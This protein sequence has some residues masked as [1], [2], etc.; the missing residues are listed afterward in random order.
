MIGFLPGFPYMG[1][2]DD[3]IAMPR[4]PSPRVRVP[5]GSVGIAGRQT[6]IYPTISPG[7]WQLIGRTTC[8]LFDVARNPPAL[9]VPGQR[10]RFVSVGPAAGA[11]TRPRE[12]GVRAAGRWPGDGAGSGPLGVPGARCARLR[13]HGHLVPS[14]CQPPRGQSGRGRHHRS[15]GRRARAGLLRRAHR[16]SG[17]RHT[18]CRGGWPSPLVSRGVRGAAGRA[19]RSRA[20]YPGVARVP[21]GER[22]V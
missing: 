7:G 8:T 19:R 2:V 22:R 13:R 17:R 6:G 3:R 5:A 10:V 4:H 1:V 15:V 11:T 14:P 12:R 9:L 18:R 16:G 21:G 20:A